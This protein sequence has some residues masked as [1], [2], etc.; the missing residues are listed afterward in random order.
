V[1]AQTSPRVYAQL[2]SGRRPVTHEQALDA[3]DRVLENLGR[4]SLTPADGVMQHVVGIA[5]PGRDA[6][7]HFD[8]AV[9]TVFLRG[10][11]SKRLPPRH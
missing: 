11:A 9:S 3:L 8:T 4:E 5:S 7:G 2:Q 1:I 6:A 10:D